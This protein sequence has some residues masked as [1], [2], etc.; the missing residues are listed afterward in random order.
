MCV[1]W[2]HFIDETNVIEEFVPQEL[3]MEGKRFYLSAVT[4]V[5]AYTDIGLLT[6][7]NNFIC[8]FTDSMAS[9]VAM[10]QRRSVITPLR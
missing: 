1:Y 3:G 5:L 8:Q 7:D 9:M 2:V 10:M 6:H 4:D